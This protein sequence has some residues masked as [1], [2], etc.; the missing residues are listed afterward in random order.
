[1]TNETKRDLREACKRL[2]VK[3]DSATVARLARTYGVAISTVKQY[4]K[5]YGKEEPKP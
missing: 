5:S 4:L 2:P 1:M 3:S